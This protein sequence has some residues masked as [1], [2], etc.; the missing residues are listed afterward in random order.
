MKKLTGIAAINA[1]DATCCNLYKYA[2]PTDDAREV[3]VEEARE[4]AREDA[5]LLFFWV[6]DGDHGDDADPPWSMWPETD[7]NCGY[8]DDVLEPAE[9]WREDQDELRAASYDDAESFGREV[10][11]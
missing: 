1:A 5:S 4:I 3:S 7:C 11:Q 10:A 2:D 8:S 9:A 6:Y